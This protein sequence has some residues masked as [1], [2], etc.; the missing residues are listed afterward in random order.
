MV[1]TSVSVHSLTTNNQVL[2]WTLFGRT[3]M[4]RSTDPMVSAKVT[5]RDRSASGADSTGCRPRNSAISARRSCQSCESFSMYA[6]PQYR[7]PRA[8][9]TMAS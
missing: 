8:P 2:S 5:L 9:R 3:W 7:I 4:P 6:V 1:Y